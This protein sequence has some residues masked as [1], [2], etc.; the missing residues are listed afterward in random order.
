MVYFAFY[1]KIEGIIL[2]FQLFFSFRFGCIIYLQ[3]IH[4]GE[5]YEK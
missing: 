4:K 3:S 1:V 2:H 5:V